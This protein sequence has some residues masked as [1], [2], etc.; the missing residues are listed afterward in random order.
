MIHIVIEYD[1]T[2]YW[3]NFV[4]IDGG[5]V[6]NVP[7]KYPTTIFAEINCISI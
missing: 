6:F 4:P 5:T 1:H 2:I 7:Y 3:I